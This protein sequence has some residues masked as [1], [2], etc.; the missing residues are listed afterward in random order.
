[1]AKLAEIFY[2]IYELAEPAEVFVAGL[3]RVLF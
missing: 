2:S 1:M 3:L